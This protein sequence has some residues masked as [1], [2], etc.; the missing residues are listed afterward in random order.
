LPEIT[1]N[2]VP[3]ITYRDVDAAI[4]WL[5]DAFDFKE[6]LVV[7]NDDGTIE[8]TELS[9]GAGVIY[10]ARER[11]NEWGLKSPQEH[12]GMNQMV[13]LTVEDA[14]A[15]FERA[16]A[17]GAEIVAEPFDTSYGSRDYLCRDLEGHL[18]GMGTYRPGGFWHNKD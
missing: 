10:L 17:A 8:H 18:W 3:S 1:T 14:D 11:E 4:A 7:R 9:Y 5:R 15:H 13:C 6:R 2:I 16:K 12:G